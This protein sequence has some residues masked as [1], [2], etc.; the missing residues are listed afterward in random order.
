MKQALNIILLCLFFISCT[1]EKLKEDAPEK[2]TLPWTK[3]KKAILLANRQ[4]TMTWDLSLLKNDLDYFVQYPS[5]LP[6]ERS[7]FPVPKYN[8]LGEGSFK[9]MGNYGSKKSIADKTLL[10]NSFFVGKNEINKTHLGDL[11]NEVFFHIIVLTN[12]IDTI[13]YS[14]FSSSVVSR[15]HPDFIGQGFYKTIENKITYSSIYYSGKEC[16]CNC[17]YEII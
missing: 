12:Y 1:K 8:L 4:D 5:K 17:E 7:T 16:L 13:N 10:Y 9:G 14:H 15:N 11:N 6:F 2:S 3:E